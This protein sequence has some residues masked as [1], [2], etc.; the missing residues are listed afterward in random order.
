MKMPDK[1]I[2]LSTLMLGGTMIVAE[3]CPCTDPLGKD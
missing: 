3:I 2:S 1:S